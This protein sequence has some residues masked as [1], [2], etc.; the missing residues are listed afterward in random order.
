[1]SFCH[2]RS[3]Q[4][5]R[6]VDLGRPPSE[7]GEREGKG[8]TER[9]IRGERGERGEGGGSVVSLCVSICSCGQ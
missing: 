5:P 8:A 6:S 4:G 9:G 2:I 1:M 3:P 7:R